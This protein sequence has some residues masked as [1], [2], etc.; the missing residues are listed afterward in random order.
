MSG[1]LKLLTPSKSGSCMHVFWKGKRL[2]ATQ[3]TGEKLLHKAARMGYEV[4][5]SVKNDG[6]F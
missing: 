4:M 3:K 6:I 5:L 1:D 2:M